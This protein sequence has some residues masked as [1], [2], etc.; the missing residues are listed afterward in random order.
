MN[1]EKENKIV[2]VYL[3]LTFFAWGSLHA[4]NRYLVGYFDIFV[5]LFTRY[6]LATIFSIA[7][8]WIEIKKSQGKGGIRKKLMVIEKP[9][10]KY[11]VLIGIVGYVGAVVLQLLGTKYSNASISSVV[12]AINPLFIII[13]AAIILK[14]RI[15][16]KKVVCLI[17]ALLGTFIIG[18]NVT[19]TVTFGVVFS[20]VA[21]MAWAAAAVITRKISFKYDTSVITFWALLLAGI[22]LL[23]MAIVQIAKDGIGNIPWQ[24]W[25]GL[26]YIGLISTG[27]AN[28]LWNKSLSM[29][30]SGKCSL[31]YPLQPVIATILG[32]VF[33]GESLTVS[34][35][36]GF[37]IIVIGVVI[38]AWEKK[39]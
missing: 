36:I 19:G 2:Y 21:A 17:L 27:M 33:L 24:A 34:F 3:L 26:V 28:L 37:V 38:N 31:F 20:G 25:V 12:N 13:F 32:V 4:V 29:M 30:E 5:I 14:E 10:I 35:M 1:D 15:T 16:A 18:S 7:V 8:I 23:P 9:D 11:I 39:S 6:L 22:C